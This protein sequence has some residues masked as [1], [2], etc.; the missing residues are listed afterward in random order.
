VVLAQAISSS[1]D[2]LVESGKTNDLDKVAA[3]TPS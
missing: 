2:Q 3:A 1:G